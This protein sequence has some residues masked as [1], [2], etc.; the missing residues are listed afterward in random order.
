MKMDHTG[1][2]PDRG[3]SARRG[4]ARLGW[5]AHRVDQAAHSRVHF[6]PT[7]PSVVFVPLLYEIHDFCEQISFVVAV[8][9]PHTCFL[10]N[11]MHSMWR[12]IHIQKEESR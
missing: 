12:Q 10:F 11:F 6:G 5:P 1:L 9:F 3:R 7:L 8:F 4:G 2:K